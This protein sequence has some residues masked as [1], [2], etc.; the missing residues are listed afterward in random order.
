MSIPHGTA[1]GYS[2][3][4]CRCKRC[5]AAHAAAHRRYLASRTRPCSV[6]GCTR[7]VYAKGRC[8]PHYERKRLD[9]AD[10]DG[11]IKET[12]SGKGWNVPAGYRM[13]RRNGKA[14]YEHRLVME[15]HLGRSLE[16]DETV[17]HK[18]G[19]RDDNRL[20]NLQLMVSIHPKGQTPDDLLTWADE[21]I[22]RY[23]PVG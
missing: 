10:P 23:R 17:H 2:N 11:P 18:N 15:D 8:Q 19:I 9:R 13:V 6:S 3:H 22:R 5:R 12:G 20:S 4:R 1:G 21:I 14:V 7:S 16:S